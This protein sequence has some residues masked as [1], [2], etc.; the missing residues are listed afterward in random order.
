M[1]IYCDNMVALAYAKCGS[2][3]RHSVLGKGVT[4]LGTINLLTYII[5]KNY[6][7]NINLQKIHIHPP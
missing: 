5:L 2:P 6:L 1:M 4:N 7:E 3:T